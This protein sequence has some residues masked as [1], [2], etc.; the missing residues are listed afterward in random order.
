MAIS[1]FDVIWPCNHLADLA[2]RCSTSTP[3]VDQLSFRL[4][5]CLACLHHITAELPASWHLV[6]T[7]AS[8][9]NALAAVISYI[10]CLGPGNALVCDIWLETQQISKVK[11]QLGKWCSTHLV[12]Y[13]LVMT[14]WCHI[15]QTNPDHVD[16]SFDSFDPIGDGEAYAVPCCSHQQAQVL[17]AVFAREPGAGKKFPGCRD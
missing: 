10:W 9:W 3:T 14:S 4:Q 15:R 13:T 6:T 16:P 1:L 5:L 17:C 7:E 8:R 11:E 12:A 2:Q